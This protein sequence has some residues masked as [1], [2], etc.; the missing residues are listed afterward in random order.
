MADETQPMNPEKLAEVRT[1]TN[2]AEKGATSFSCTLANTGYWPSSL[3][4][5][6]SRGGTEG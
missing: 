6:A 3:R 2:V 5:L 1:I 4:S